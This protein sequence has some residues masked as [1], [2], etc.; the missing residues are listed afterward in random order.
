MDYK[1]DCL[2]E[3]IEEIEDAGMKAAAIDTLLLVLQ[4]IRQTI[5]EEDARSNESGEITARK[6]EIDEESK[7]DTDVVFNKAGP[8]KSRE[9]LNNTIIECF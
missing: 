6:D 7:D 8:V 1:I 3:G 5:L 9:E 4:E 2:F